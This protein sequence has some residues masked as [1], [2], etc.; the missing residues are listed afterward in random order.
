VS[1]LAGRRIL[2]TGGSQGIGREV[3][4]AVAAAGGRVVV[5]ARGEEAVRAVVAELPGDGHLGVTLD[6]ALE[7]SWDA[8]VNDIGRPLHGLVAAAGALEPVGAPGTYPPEEFLRTVRV[9]L[10]GTWLAVTACLPTLRA[11]GDGAILTFSGGG[12]TAP[13]PR[14]HAYAASKAAIV[15]L[16]ENLAPELAADGITINAIGPGFVATR[17]HDA[18]LEAGPERAGALHARTERQLAEGGVPP[19]AAA[20]LAVF[21]LSSQARGISGK[22]VSAQWD[23][24]RDPAFRTRLAADP[25]FATLRRIDDQPYGRVR[26]LR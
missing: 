17:I 12:A 7:A 21:L 2:V 11:A 23:D 15:R 19:E 10:Y 3:A 22:L 13:L 8:A 20:E 5:A 1:E 25:D 16:T 24:W 4:R 6:V 9:N 14:V 18:V 26:P